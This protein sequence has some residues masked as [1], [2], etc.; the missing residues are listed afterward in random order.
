M[1]LLVSLFLIFPL[2]ER[3]S[4]AKHLQMMT[5]LNP[6]TFWLTNLAW[7]FLIYLVSSALMV[8]F[9]MVLDYDHTF[10]S[11]Q[12]PGRPI[13]CKM[14]T[15]KNSRYFEKIR[16]TFY[17]ALCQLLLPILLRFKFF[18][19]SKYSTCGTS[20]SWVVASSD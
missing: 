6:M 17:A 7:D 1:S 2:V 14:A 4:G 18:S 5:G 3:T 12:A 9:L 19:S 10:T 13:Q 20:Q 16:V 11:F 8:L 15:R